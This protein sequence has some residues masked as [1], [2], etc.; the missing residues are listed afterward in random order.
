MGDGHRWV[1][2]GSAFLL[3]DV[4]NYGIKEWLQ[5]IAA[6]IAIF[7]AIIGAWRTYRYSKYQ[8]AKRLLEYLEDEASRITASRNRIIRHLRQGEPLNGDLDHDFYR[9]VK[10]AL[11]ELANGDPRQA[12]KKLNAFTETLAG[13]IK[14]GQTYLSNANL[15]LATVL[16]VRGKSANERS[17]ATA[18]RTAWEGALQ[19]YSHDAEA[20]RYLG[21]LALAE[22][23]LEAAVGHFGSSIAL[24]PDDKLLKAETSELLATFHRERGKVTPEIEALVECAPSFVNAGEYHRAAAAYARAGEIAVQLN[25]SR[26]GPRLLR[27]AFDNYKLA[28]DQNGM[29]EMRSRL[30]DLEEDVSGLQL[31]E[32]EPTRQIPWF[33]IRL[34]F[35]LSIL[36]VAAYLFLSLR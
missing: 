29:R 35:E 8:I 21:E 16:L 14:L 3:L 5:L 7:V 30:V 36:G 23:D 17:E 10:G 25:R 33:W 19:C 31:D 28:G 34:A 11:D 13:D 20:A 9:E 26:Q 32:K 1:L 12:E 15:Q 4:S 27:D 18:A 6:A 22:G 2:A 24:A